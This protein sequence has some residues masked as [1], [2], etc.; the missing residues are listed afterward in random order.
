[1]W[2]VRMMEGYVWSEMLLCSK[3]VCSVAVVINSYSMWGCVVGKRW[4]WQSWVIMS[5]SFYK[6]ILVF[7][8]SPQSSAVV[9]S[10]IREMRRRMP[11]WWQVSNEEKAYFVL[12]RHHHARNDDLQATRPRQP[13][14]YEQTMTHLRALLLLIGT[15]NTTTGG[16]PQQ[17]VIGHQWRFGTM[18]LAGCVVRQD[19]KKTPYNTSR[20]GLFRRTGV[21][22]T[23]NPKTP[24]A[25]TFRWPPSFC[26]RSFAADHEE[27]GQ[28]TMTTVFVS[29]KANDAA[30]RYGQFL[31][32][33]LSICFCSCVDLV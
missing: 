33:L 30:C 2:M 25:W 24:H 14:Y 23:Q 9:D 22:V 10:T 27:R 31:K 13:W 21:S 19:V 15:N 26:T 4:R 7:G 8:Q 3:N 17:H 16:H 18:M 12:S 29:S 5:R 28:R 11:K 32:L 1:M 6:I 20:R